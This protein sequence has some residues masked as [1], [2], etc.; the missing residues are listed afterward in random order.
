M[1]INFFRSK[2]V[3]IGFASIFVFYS[4]NGIAGDGIAGDGVAGDGVAV[5]A[6]GSLLVVGYELTSIGSN[7]RIQTYAPAV[8]FGLQ[9]NVYHYDELSIDFDYR[10]GL[11]M[12]G[13]SGDITGSLSNPHQV[14][15]FLGY[16]ELRARYELL[17]LTNEPLLGYVMVGPNWSS[18][19]RNVPSANTSDTSNQLGFQYGAGIEYSNNDWSVNV[20]YT[21]INTNTKLLFSHNPKSAYLSVG[22]AAVNFVYRF[23]SGL[24]DM[25]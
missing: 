10:L 3:L 21:Q 11:L 6:G 5:F 25:F 8:Q 1:V 15:L 7:T 19:T 23:D 17:G 20:E 2:L 18:I 22:S 24:M 16:L 12:S 13:T 4:V 9:E 14:K